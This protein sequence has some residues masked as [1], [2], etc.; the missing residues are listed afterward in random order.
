MTTLTVGRG[1]LAWALK[2]VLPHASRNDILP[3]LGAVAV[4]VDADG[5]LWC[6]ATDRYTI[7]ATWTQGAATSAEPGSTLLEIAD[8]K[9]L[10]RRLKG[11]GDVDLELYGDGDLT[12]GYRVR[13]SR[14]GG[15]A[16]YPLE[17]PDWRKLLGAMLRWPASTPAR[18]HQVNAEF[19][20]RF[21][22]A[23]PA[24]HRSGLTFMPVR[25]SARV[26]ACVV[27]GGR[28]AGVAM[29][30]ALDAPDPDPAAMLADWRTAFAGKAVS[31]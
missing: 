30:T 4:E 5:R 6:A 3:V 18:T 27:V 20:A 7:G 10:L 1:E 31:S 24:D 14:A 9:D 26:H 17:F 29:G 8:V 2:A 16:D 21:A 22:A 28:F 25:K 15:D 11:V 23:A 19:M 13:Y 12:V